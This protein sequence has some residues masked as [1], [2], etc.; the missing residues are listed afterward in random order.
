MSTRPDFEEHPGFALVRIAGQPYERGLQHGRLLRDGVRRLRD[1]FHRE[2]VNFRGRLLGLA[3]QAAAAPILMRLH[4]HVPPEL[5]LEMRG[6]ADGAG[7]RYWDILALNY[8]DDLVHGLWRIPLMLTRLPWLNRRFTCSSFA[9]LGERTASGRLL[10]GRNMDYE[11]ADYLAAPGVVTQT[12]KDNVVAIECQ[13]DRGH[14][15]LSVGWPGIIGV[16]TGLNEAGLS[17]ACLTS[18][19]EDETAGGIPTPMLYR[20][21]SQYAGSLAEAQDQIRAVR[22]TIG[23]NVL[24]ASGVEQDARVFE[25]SR[26]LVAVRSPHNG[27]LVTTNHF[28][29]ESAIP[30]QNGWVVPASVDRL[31]RLESLCGTKDCGP[32]QARD[33]LR[34]TYSLAPDGNTWS[35]L[36]N[37]GTIYST[38]AEP[39]SG[40]LWLRVNDRPERDFVELTLGALRPVGTSRVA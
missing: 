23:N 24:I 5:R 4:R 15:F 13:P 39:A 31:N 32:E 35:C 17:L 40:R 20:Q 30:G 9:L 25:L 29:H 28:V 18:T 21:I 6:V 37:P 2:V 10:H 33:F 38:V 34:D 19:I 14:A 8:F 11:V 1:A 27:F 16:V 3:F 36:E 7:V 22:L 26:R 12:L